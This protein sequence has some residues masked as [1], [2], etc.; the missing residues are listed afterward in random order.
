MAKLNATQKK[1]VG[2]FASAM[3]LL[4]AKREG[5]PVATARKVLDAFVNNIDTDKPKGGEDLKAAMLRELSGGKPQADGKWMAILEKLWPFLMQLLPIIFGFLSILIVVLCLAVGDASAQCRSGRCPSVS[6]VEAP[7]AAPMPDQAIATHPVAKAA[8]SV[9]KAPI[10]VA[11]NSRQRRVER[12]G[13]YLGKWAGA[14][15]R[16][17]CGR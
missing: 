12:G 3:F 13:W 7:I 1:R 16:G 14:V 10:M 5:V 9:L 17:G 2:L 6:A 11:H 15:L 8:V 4:K